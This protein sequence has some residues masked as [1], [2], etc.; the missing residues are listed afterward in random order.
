[1]TPTLDRTFVLAT[2]DTY[3]KAWTTRDPELIVTIFTPDATYHEYVLAEPIR[4][5][6][7]IRHYW[8]TRVQ[9]GQTD[10]KFKLLSLYLDGQ[11]AIAEWEAWFVLTPSGHRKHMK[12]VAILEFRG[13]RIASL[14]EYWSSESLDMPRPSQRR[15]PARR[16]PH[17]RG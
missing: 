12:E 1:M 8:L 17:R 16:P 13:N 6:A 7:G 10:I 14:R 5:H 15:P 3:A 9:R 11:T 4:G 2:I